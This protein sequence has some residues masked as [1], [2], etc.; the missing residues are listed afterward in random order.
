MIYTDIDN[1]TAKL[2]CFIFF[3]PQQRDNEDISK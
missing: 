3:I 2:K 1:D